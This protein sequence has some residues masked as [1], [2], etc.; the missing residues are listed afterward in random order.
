VTSLLV[1]VTVA[2][3]WASAADVR[4]ANAAMATGVVFISGSPLISR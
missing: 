2:M 3:F 4:P 1:S